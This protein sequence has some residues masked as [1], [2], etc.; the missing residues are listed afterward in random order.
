M[1]L[2]TAIDICAGTGIGSW[3]FKRIGLARTACYIEKDTICQE[4][5]QA[6]IKDGSIDDAPI[7]DDITTFDGKPW[8]GYVDFIFGGIPCQPWSSIGPRTGVHDKRNLWP[9]FRRLLVQ[10]RPTFALIE[11]VYGF[12]PFGGLQYILED[13]ASLGYDAEWDVISAKAVGAHHIRKRIWV[14]I[15]KR[16]VANANCV[17]DK[18]WWESIQ[19][20][21]S[22]GDIESLIPDWA[23]GTW[24]RPA[25]AI[26][27]DF[28]RVDYGLP[29]RIHRISALGNAWVPQVAEVVGE[30]IKFLIEN[31]G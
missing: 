1:G 5:L 30:R 29:S 19:K 14:V 10:I 6:R 23:G 31:M 24:P 20:N 27:S 25:P 8:R 21:K 15:Y 3:A 26:I 2:L 11:N 12:I 18:R 4:L 22:Y 9:S 7:W 16:D 13:I 17:S 28:R